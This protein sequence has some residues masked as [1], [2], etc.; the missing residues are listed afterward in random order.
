MDGRLTA[1]EEQVLA[2]KCEALLPPS[3]RLRAPRGGRRGDLRE[4][5]G[6]VPLELHWLIRQKSQAQQPGS[7]LCSGALRCM[8]I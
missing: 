5:G 4:G 1:K 8:Q 2:Q 6:G 7:G 3:W